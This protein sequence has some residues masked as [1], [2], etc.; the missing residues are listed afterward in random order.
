[1]SAHADVVIDLRAQHIE[2]FA[3]LIAAEFDCEPG[4]IAEAVNERSC[5]ELRHRV[6]P[7]RITVLVPEPDSLVVDEL[8]YARK[9]CLDVAG[10]QHEIKLSSPEDLVVCG[11]VAVRQG[12]ADAERHY[13]CVRALIGAQRD[14]LDRASLEASA[15]QSGV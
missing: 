6:T 8:A 9:E 13:A 7:A 3:H 14:Q 2:P 10:M 15:K 5:I 1:E 11:L 4:A 12:G